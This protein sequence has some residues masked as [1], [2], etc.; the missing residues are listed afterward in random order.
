M[1]KSYAS[2]TLVKYGSAVEATLG[3]GGPKLEFINFRRPLP[4]E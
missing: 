1:K 4:G 3:N 2:P